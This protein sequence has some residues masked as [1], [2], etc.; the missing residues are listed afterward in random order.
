[1][2]TLEN[3]NYVAT[4]ADITALVRQHDEAMTA[5]GTARATYL[6][7]LVA[8]TQAELGSPVRQRGARAAKIAA[9]EIAKQVAAMEVVQQRFYAA[10]LQAIGEG[11]P[12]QRNARANFARTAASTLRRW[13][14]AGNDVR[15]LAAAR[16]TKEALRITGA[17]RRTAS[18][19]ARRAERTANR[20]T[21]M[22]TELAKADKGAAIAALEAA[23]TRI[24]SMLI[25]LGQK[26]TTKPAEA[27]SEHKPFRTR[28]GLFWPASVPAGTG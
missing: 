18:P 2:T 19:T 15:A 10:V 11:P 9:E 17:A 1:M 26:P 5:Q 3:R 12:A 6:K 23:M 14:K 8:T 20:F 28:E 4:P 25:A 13:I 7:A 16:V 27:M 24:A 22:V 21:D